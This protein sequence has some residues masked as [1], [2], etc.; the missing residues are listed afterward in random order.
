[1]SAEENRAIVRRWMDESYSPGHFDRMDAF[2]APD[3]V[4]HD[5]AA[6]EVHDLAGLKH[7]FREQRAAFPDLRVTLEDMIAEGDT[8]AT[9]VTVYATLTG[10][11]K[12]MPP[13]GKSVTTP[14][15]SIYR[16]KDG[17]IQ[18][19]WFGRDSLSALQQLGLI[20]MPEQ[21]RD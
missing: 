4:H 21:A 20:P 8:V 14:V 17:K 18:E 9:R 2:F 3:F 11:F 12:G 5:P 16:L 19:L 1:M 13:T 15:L 6:P 7:Y 10:E